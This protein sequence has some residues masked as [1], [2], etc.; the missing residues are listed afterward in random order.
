MGE[1]TV[2]YGAQ[3]DGLTIEQL[4]WLEARCK[5]IEKEDDNYTLIADFLDYDDWGFWEPGEFE[6]ID[7]DGG[8]VELGSGG[9]EHDAIGSSDHLEE[10]LLQ[11][12]KVFN[13]QKRI[14][15]KGAS[16]VPYLDSSAPWAWVTL[17]YKGQAI[18]KT[19]DDLTK[20]LLTTK[21]KDPM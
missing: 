6:V 10:L 11:F 21:V 13:Y 18:S 17:I 20:S 4:E 2:C 15:I 19:I 7:R 8:I 1:F 14:I 9:G 16:A 5:K 3:L 12:Q